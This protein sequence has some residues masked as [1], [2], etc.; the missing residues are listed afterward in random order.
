MNSNHCQALIFIKYL[1]ATHKSKNRIKVLT[2]QD[3]ASNLNLEM[4]AVG[5]HFIL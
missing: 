4:S 1:C 3:A 5:R 2:C